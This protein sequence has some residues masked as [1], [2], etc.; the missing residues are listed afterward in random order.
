[1]HA[2]FL[3]AA[4]LFAVEFPDTRFVLCGDGI[5]ESN[6]ELASLVDQAGIRQKIMLLGR[7]RPDEIA[8]IMSRSIA[9]SSSSWGEAFSN[10]IGEA[11]ACGAICVVTDVGDSA[12]IVGDCGIVVSPGSPRDLAAGWARVAS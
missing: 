10:V 9:T 8:L 4:R 11:M 7:R 2:T 5:D 12:Y 3:E 1:D 6:I